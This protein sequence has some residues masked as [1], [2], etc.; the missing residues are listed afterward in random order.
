MFLV[1]V[2]MISCPVQ[3]VLGLLLVAWLAAFMLT[4]PT[5]AGRQWWNSLP[6][7]TVPIVALGVPL[8][9]ALLAIWWM[10][11]GRASKVVATRL[12]HVPRGKFLL[13]LSLG[14]V[15]AQFVAWFVYRHRGHSG[16]DFVGEVGNAFAV[17]GLA[18]LAVLL[19]PLDHSATLCGALGHPFEAAVALHRWL[20]RAVVACYG[21]HGL[22]WCTVSLM[23][24]ALF[25]PPASC[26]HKTEFDGDCWRGYL[27]LTGLCAISVLVAL[28]LL[29]R[30]TVRRSAY[31]TFYFSHVALAPLLFLTAALH[32]RK[33]S[34]WLAPSLVLHL[35]ARLPALLSALVRH[36]PVRARSLALVPGAERP[37]LQLEFPLTA[38]PHAPAPGQWVRVACPTV[39][40]MVW[41]PLTVAHCTAT[42]FVV[43]LR[44]C[45]RPDSWS[46]LLRLSV[47]LT[48]PAASVRDVQRFRF[49]FQG[50]YGRNLLD[51]SQQYSRLLLVAGGVGFTPLLALLKGVYDAHQAGQAPP[52]GQDVTLVWA[53]RD[54]GLLL[55][56][57]RILNQFAGLPSLRLRCRMHWTGDTSVD[58]SADASIPGKLPTSASAP[59]PAYSRPTATLWLQTMTAVATALGYAVGALF[60]YFYMQ[61]DKG[62][63]SGRRG[64][65][66]YLLKR[67]VVFLA[68]MGSALLA[69]AAVWFA[70]HLCTKTKDMGDVPTELA[71]LESAHKIVETLDA[72]DPESGTCIADG[73][74]DLS[75]V[76]MEDTQN[77]ADLDRIGL[78][79]CGP[80]DLE[81]SVRALASASPHYIIHS[82]TFEL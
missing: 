39:S 73:R 49:R 60:P 4:Y 8:L 7:D 31:R 80:A 13:G 52:A 70:V 19:L 54:R 24:G 53:A 1:L 18:V 6:R 26:L 43:Y 27:M 46:H 17:L 68:A 28:A 23:E 15:G 30:E 11:S 78:F 38:L 74:P 5:P 14:A 34:L 22:V 12:S 61:G 57:Q 16:W 21:A 64:M 9:G 76:F 55:H 2:I 77:V 47:E 63:E 71:A 10:A 58:Q 79:V 44:M 67:L 66:D 48:D 3:K 82:E 32:Y 41:H 36:S 25:V 59:W 29:S 62:D 51:L 65:G 37:V 50:P 45:P 35:S 56:V 81:R 42:S 69:G 72:K 40:R 20:G 33:I 75:A